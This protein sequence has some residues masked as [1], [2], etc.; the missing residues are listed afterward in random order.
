MR[1]VWNA[2]GIVSLVVLVLLVV[3]ACGGDTDSAQPAEPVSEPASP[4]EPTPESAPA[5]EP[6]S[7]EPAPSADAEPVEVAAFDSAE[8]RS[9]LRAVLE[10][11]LAEKGWAAACLTSNLENFSSYVSADMLIGIDGA[12]LALTRRPPQAL[13]PTAEEP[14]YLV[15]SAANGYTGT[16]STE[17]DELQGEDY[18]CLRSPIPEPEPTEMLE[19]G[20]VNEGY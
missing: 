4:S 11:A 10:P 13:D 16:P 14:L 2:W 3:A 12:D 1:K 8:N 20:A 18:Y 17:L 15:L 6:P 7:P 5:A 19:P 9:K